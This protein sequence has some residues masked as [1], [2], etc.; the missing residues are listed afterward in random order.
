MIGEKL[1]VYVIAAEERTTGKTG[2]WNK[3]KGWG[4]WEPEICLPVFYRTL[5]HAR[6]GVQHL[7]Q[8]YKS[9]AYN[10]R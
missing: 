1:S 10:I 9:S 8:Y 6:Q 7:T 4:R 3:Q 5:G 2:Y